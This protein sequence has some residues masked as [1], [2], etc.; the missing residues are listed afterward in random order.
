MTFSSAASPFPL[1]LTSPKDGL[2]RRFRFGSMARLAPNG[3]N[4][5]RMLQLAGRIAVHLFALLFS[6]RTDSGTDRGTD[7]GTDRHDTELGL[8][9][10]L[11]LGL[12]L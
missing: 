1:P 7:S 9:L 4:L 11:G 10:G 2:W 8:Q 6:S 3:V 12:T 5:I